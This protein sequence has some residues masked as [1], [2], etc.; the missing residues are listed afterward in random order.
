MELSCRIHSIVLSSNSVAL[1][2]QFLPRKQ[3]M[4]AELQVRG[5]AVTISVWDVVVPR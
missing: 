3:T 1:S 5:S 4:F 2:V